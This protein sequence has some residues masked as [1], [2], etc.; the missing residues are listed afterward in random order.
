MFTY[1]T[2]SLFF[3]VHIVF[4]PFSHKKWNDSNHVVLICDQR[5]TKI[6][7]PWLAFTRDVSPY[8]LWISC[9]WEHLCSSCLLLVT[10]HQRVSV[11]FSITARLHCNYLPAFFFFFT[12]PHLMLESVSLIKCCFFVQSSLSYLLCHHLQ[13]A[14]PTAVWKEPNVGLMSWTVDLLGGRLRSQDPLRRLQQST[15]PSSTVSTKRWLGS[16]CRQAA[17]APTWTILKS[18]VAA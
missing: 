12:H 10:D 3:N 11:L 7:L 6:W 15:S 14:M 2:T 5:I 18:F 1:R 4:L 16:W 13:R 9:D 17:S 8:E